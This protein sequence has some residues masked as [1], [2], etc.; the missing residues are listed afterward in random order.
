L[1]KGGVTVG[2]IDPGPVKLDQL[3]ICQNTHVGSDWEV[4]TKEQP[5][6]LGRIRMGENG[7]DRGRKE[8]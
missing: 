1:S 3:D 7:K 4:E 6:K 5:G 2:T 8:T